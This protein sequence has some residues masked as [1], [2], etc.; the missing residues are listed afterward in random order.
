MKRIIDLEN[1]NRKEHF[2]FFS[3][4]EDPF[5]GVTTTVDFTEAYRQSKSH[6]L[7]FFLYSTHLLL[8]AANAVDAFRLRTDGDKIV[9]F[10]E[11][12]LSPT[13]G[14]ADGTFGFGFFPFHADWEAFRSAA[15]A[16]IRRVESGTGLCLTENAARK[17]VIYYSALPWFAFSEMKHAVSFRDGSS[18]P[19]ISTGKLLEE[20][21]R[22][23]L[24][25]SVC[26]HHG[27]ADGRDVALFLEAVK[28]KQAQPPFPL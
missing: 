9:L 13:I 1:W 18:V 25:V 26:L 23:L 21:G 27:L 20:N 24:P 22:F 17:D 4:L 12:H 16:D 11:I 28:E 5:F 2:R 6:G 15:Q 7:P 10:D 3:A 19:R 14:R 8:R